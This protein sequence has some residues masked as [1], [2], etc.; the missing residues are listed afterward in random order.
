MEILS[1]TD[2]GDADNPF[3]PNYFVDI[4]DYIEKKINALNIYD[5]EM[6]VPPFPRNYE[7][8]RALATLRGGMSGVRYA[9]AFKII[10]WIE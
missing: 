1:E 4:S 10:K 2:F 5:T 3:I 8:I 9:E 7:A 6:G